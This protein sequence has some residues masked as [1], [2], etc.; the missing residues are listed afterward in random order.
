MTTTYMSNAIQTLQ[1]SILSILRADTTSLTI[2][3]ADGTTGTIK[4]SADVKILDGIPVDMLKGIG[5]PYIIVHTPEE[6]TER[7]T[8]SKHKTEFTVHIEILDRR[9]SN[10]RILSDEVKNALDSNQNTTKGSGYTLFGRRIRTN[11]NSVSLPNEEKM[12]PIWH[13][14]M[15]FTYLWSG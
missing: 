4:L 7:L 3:Y 10:V 14:N 6:N 15:F 5:F 2:A 8:F 12:K 11:I 9:E 13:M 1:S